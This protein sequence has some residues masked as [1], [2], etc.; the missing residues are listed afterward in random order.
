MSVWVGI[1]TRGDRD[2]GPL[3]AA[4]RSQHAERVVVVCN[5]AEPPAALAGQCAEARAVLV[6]EPR[7]GYASV[8]NALLDAAA[9]APEM[10]VMIDDDELP[11]DG[12]LQALCEVR[13]RTGA[14]AVLGPVLTRWPEGTSMAVRRADLPRRRRRHPDGTQV[15]D[16]ITGNC[17]LHLPSLAGLRF[18]V[19][20][21]TS[22]G[23]DARFFRDLRLA[24]GRVVWSARAVVTEEPD[25]SRLG[26]RALCARSRRNGA[27]VAAIACR[28]RARVLLDNHRRVAKAGLLLAAGV[29]L[30]R[31]DLLLRAAWEASFL[32][33]VLGIRRSAS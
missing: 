11:E 28:G 26:V 4:V 18:D 25:A 22:G 14:A 5:Q 3:L 2:L 15:P 24:G 8:R 12:W 7:K 31:P 13:E 30:R 21:D 9:A 20:F 27:A 6:L 33:G 10:L 32:A 29:V 19:G 1:P 16:G 23:E 17:L